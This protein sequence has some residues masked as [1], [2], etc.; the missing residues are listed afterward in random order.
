[1]TSPSGVRISQSASVEPVILAPQSTV[2]VLATAG[3]SNVYGKKVVI[4]GAQVA[5]VLTCSPSGAFLDGGE[6]LF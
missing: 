1:M 2:T 5:G 3:A 6:P 4:K